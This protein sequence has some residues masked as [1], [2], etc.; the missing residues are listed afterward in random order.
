M[1]MNDKINLIEKSIKTIDEKIT[2]IEIRY[3]EEKEKLQN[4]FLRIE[5]LLNRI[6]ENLNKEK[7]FKPDYAKELKEVRKKI[8]KYEELIQLNGG[9]KEDI[10]RLLIDLRKQEENLIEKEEGKLIIEEQ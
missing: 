3:E 5:N 1:S 10:E 4:N 7:P 2:R 9:L 6:I 8:E